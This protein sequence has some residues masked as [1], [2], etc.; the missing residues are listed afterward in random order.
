MTLN[1]VTNKL[2]KAELRAPRVSQTGKSKV[3]GFSYLIELEDEE[4]TQEKIKSIEIYDLGAR[5]LVKD[6]GIFAKILAKNEL[7][8]KIEEE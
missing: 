7:W 5:I 8:E 1:E 6:R 4:K 2:R 3:L